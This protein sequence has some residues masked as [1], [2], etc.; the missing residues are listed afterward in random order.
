MLP[1]FGKVLQEAGCV[2]IGSYFKLHMFQRQ[3]FDYLLYVYCYSSVIVVIVCIKIT[4]NLK[5]VQ[6]KQSM[7]VNG[8]IICH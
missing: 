1:H 2:R 4:R 5:I 6:H 3:V 7:W 8:I